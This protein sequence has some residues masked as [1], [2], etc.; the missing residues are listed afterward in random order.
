MEEAMPETFGE[1]GRVFD[2]LENHYR[3]M[4]DI[5]LT[6]ERGKLWMLQTRSGKRHAKAAPK[7]AVDM[8]AEGLISE[9]EAVGR[10]DPGELDQ[11]RHPTLEP[12]AARVVLTKGDRTSNRP[13]SS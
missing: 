13:H 3:D 2:T 4:Q 9:Q 11:L 7:I 12:H 6:V 8:A 10:V 1:L 5:E